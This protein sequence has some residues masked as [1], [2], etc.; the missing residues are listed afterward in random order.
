MIVDGI[1]TAKYVGRPM[2]GFKKGKYTIKIT[3]LDTQY[4]IESM[5]D[6]GYIV[7]SSEKS[8]N[9]YFENLEYSGD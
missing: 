6:D 7:L 4:M 1:Y 8:V 9:K 5:I 3:K 2:Q